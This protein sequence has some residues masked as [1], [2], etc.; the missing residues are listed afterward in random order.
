MEEIIRIRRK[1]NTKKLANDE[2]GVKKKRNAP[3]SAPAS[4]LRVASTG[5]GPAARRLQVIVCSATLNGPIRRE[6]EKFR[7]WLEDPVLLDVKGGHVAPQHIKHHCLILDGQTATI[8]N[9][10]DREEEERAYSEALA[11]AKEEAEKLKA[12]GVVVDDP[13]APWSKPLW[14]VKM[15]NPALPDDDDMIMEQVAHI[16][17]REKITRGILFLSSNISVIRVVEKLRSLGVKA[18]RVKDEV[19]FDRASGVAQISAE[20]NPQDMLKAYSSFFSGENHLLVDTEHTARG[21]D[22]PSVTHVIM[23]GPP[24]SPGSYLH[25]SGRVG[26]FGK[27]GTSILI[28]GGERYERKMMDIF[29]LLKIK[30]TA[31]KLD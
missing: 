3:N 11:T 29:K 28:L 21:L 16:C 6:L 4:L 8:R 26:R 5:V 17:Y 9:I 10:R 27:P 19:D 31:L 22:L 15:E 14:K 24:S 2:I 18:G 23:V 12:R 13:E 25:M 20:L 30:P 1:G 7:G